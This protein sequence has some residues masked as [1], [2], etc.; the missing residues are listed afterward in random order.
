M[1][2]AKSVD[3]KRRRYNEGPDSIFCPGSQETSIDP[4]S[5]VPRALRDYAVV[6]RYSM[7][8]LLNLPHIRQ[9]G[10]AVPGASVRRPSW[11]PAVETSV[12]TGHPLGS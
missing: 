3:E 4:L 5:W 12:V 8:L 11:H 7:G 6:K 9:G 10:K 2:I 1:R